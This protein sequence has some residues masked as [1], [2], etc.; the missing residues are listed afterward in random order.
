[1]KKIFSRE[2][3][4]GIITIFSLVVLYFGI[5]YLK[6]V[7]LFKPTNHYYIK[8]NDVTDLQKASPVYVEGY[9]IGVVSDINYD[10]AHPGNIFA[11]ISLDKSMKIQ[12]GSY[13]ELTSSLTTGASLHI[14]LNKFVS[15]YCQIG[16]TLEGKSRIGLMDVVSKALLPQIENIMPKIDSIL[17]GLQEILN[18]PALTQSLVSIQRSTANLENSTASLNKVLNRDVPVILSNFKTISSDFTEVSSELKSLNLTTT[19]NSLNKTLSNVENMSNQLNSNNN[20]FGLLL[21]DRTLYDNLN[22]TT[23]NAS[24]LL[25]DFKQNPKRY[26]HFS[27]F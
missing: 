16:D 6:G 25:L 1:M 14:M 11:I 19:Y 17:V 4:I 24:N 18:H 26:V 5:N 7:N 10:Y 22:A 9:R 15:S 23:E 2:V 20:S 3:V 21:N 27:I 8:F 12:Q 13:I